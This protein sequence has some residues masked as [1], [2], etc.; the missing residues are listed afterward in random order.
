MKYRYHFVVLYKFRQNYTNDHT[1]ELYKNFVFDFSALLIMKFIKLFCGA[2]LYTHTVLN[3]F[4]LT[5]VI[6]HMC[7]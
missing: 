7:D 6:S 1:L 4:D 2:L 5:F 3:K